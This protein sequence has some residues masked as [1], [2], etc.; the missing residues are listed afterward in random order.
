MSSGNTNIDLK[1]S[2]VARKVL[3]II[4]GV[5]NT[6]QSNKYGFYGFEIK[7]G[8]ILQFFFSGF[9]AFTTH[10]HLVFAGKLLRVT[11]QLLQ[12]RFAS[13]HFMWK[14]TKRQFQHGVISNAIIRLGAN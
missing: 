7:M 12:E 2:G 14:T 5:H 1:C 8:E 10:G 6:E 3:Y 9:F 13:T 11:G 4:M